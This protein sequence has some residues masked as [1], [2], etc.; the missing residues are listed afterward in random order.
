MPLQNLKNKFKYHY[1]KYLAIFFVTLA[2]AFVTSNVIITFAD[3]FISGHQVSLSDLNVVL[4]FLILMFSYTMILKGNIRGDVTAF[5]GVL[6]FIFLL[7]F[8]EIFTLIFTYIA[9]QLNFVSYFQSGQFLFGSL[10]LIYHLLLIFQIVAGIIAYRNLRQYMNGRYVSV[11]KMKVWFY[12]YLGLF[13]AAM[14]VSIA[15]NFSASTNLNSAMKILLVL[16]EPLSEF[17]C[18]ISC[19]FTM[20]RLSD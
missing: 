11:T 12:I 9:G 5:S 10:L 20:M 2:I 7:L 6:S 16:L 1:K 8:S 18:G 15:I 14:G 17:V 4:S 13:I 19:V 3:I